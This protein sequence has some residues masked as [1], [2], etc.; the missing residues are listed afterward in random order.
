MIKLYDKVI[1][2]KSGIKGEVIDISSTKVKTLYIVESD[3][4]NVAG[5]YGAEN[6]YKLF[7]CEESE[8]EVTHGRKT[9][10]SQG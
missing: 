10:K 6:N 4:K 9:D 3:E 7:W 1:I 5:G 2:K 8:L